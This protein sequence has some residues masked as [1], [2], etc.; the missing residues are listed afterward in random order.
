MVLFGRS[1]LPEPVSESRGADS[2]SLS[3]ESMPSFTTKDRNSRSNFFDESRLP[4]RGMLP[5]RMLKEV[6]TCEEVREP[7]PFSDGSPLDV[8]N[9][10]DALIEPLPVSRD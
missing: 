6:C 9:E 4:A 5:G 8:V 2:E 3:T 7:L 10:S 1:R